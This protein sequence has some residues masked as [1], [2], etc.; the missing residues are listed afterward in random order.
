MERG[1][2]KLFPLDVMDVRFERSTS[3]HFEAISSLLCIINEHNLSSLPL[4]EPRPSAMDC[5][6]GRS[7]E[8]ITYDFI[9]Y[10]RLL[11]IRKQ[12]MHNYLM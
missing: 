10:F 1:Y 11:L 9:Q 5:N 3:H 7:I 2:S 12:K 8:I 6:D 4:S